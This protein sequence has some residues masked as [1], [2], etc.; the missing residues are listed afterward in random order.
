MRWLIA[1]ISA[2]LLIGIASGADPAE[3]MAD[4]LSGGYVVSHHW[5]HAYPVYHDSTFIDPWYR[6]VAWPFLSSWY[7]PPYKGGVTVHPVR[8]PYIYYPAYYWY[9]PA[10]WYPVYP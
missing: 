9:R 5:D 8:Y 10:W 2:C 4:W 1:T 7:W 3:E 6:N